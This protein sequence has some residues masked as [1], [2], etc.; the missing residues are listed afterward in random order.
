MLLHE[1]VTP[2]ES[3][4][5][6]EIGVGR[7]DFGI[8]FDSDRRE[9]GIGGKIAARSSDC[10][11]LSEQ[12]ETTGSRLNDPDNGQPEPGIHNTE[13][14]FDLKRLRQDVGP[15]CEPQE[16]EQH[17][18]RETNGL[19]PGKSF[20][21]PSFRSTVKR[22]ID[23]GSVDQ[24]IHIRNDDRLPDSLIF[25]IV[26]SSSS[27]SASAN[28]FVRSTSAGPHEYAFWT[29]RRPASPP[30]D[31]RPARSVS[32]SAW[33]KSTFRSQPSAEAFLRRPGQDL[34]RPA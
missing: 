15:G 21:Q 11:Q 5:S 20:F 4:E 13:G 24:K 31:Y 16:T 28:A 6:A 14:L 27:S 22:F 10:Q 34:R 32:L 19:G 33:S 7:I 3:R 8:V 26:S 12:L 30:S 29:K 25:R 1:R 17:V 9:M 23:I 2:A 18:P